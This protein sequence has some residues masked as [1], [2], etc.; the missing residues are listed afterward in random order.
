MKYR[1]KIVFFS[2]L[3]L[4][5]V[6]AISFTL[7]SVDTISTST[8]ENSFEPTIVID[9]G[10]GGFDG[11][12]V[13]GDNILEKNINLQISRK[14]YDFLKSNGFNVKMTRYEDIALY[15]QV[16]NKKRSD[17]TNRVD[18]FN[19]NQDNIVISIHQNMFTDSRYFGTQVFFSNNNT[20]SSDLAE[21]IRSS[22]VSLIQ[23]E[24]T[25]QC[26]KAG[27][28]IFVLDKATVPA[29][30]VECGFMSNNDEII[31]L[32]DNEYQNKLA[33]S[34]YLGFLEYYYTNY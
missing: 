16:D 2:S 21:C 8:K 25:R 33:Y 28:E 1:L 13:A 19:S 34:V 5:I 29:V 6:T 17:L 11:G 18:I 4:I 14:L 27:S 31:K 23:P 9:P 12:A 10:H 3:F 20:K 32:T 22:V 24:N 7:T 30:M 26:K 15:S